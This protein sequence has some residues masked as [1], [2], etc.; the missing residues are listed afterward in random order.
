M[1]DQLKTL[2]AILVGQSIINFL[3]LE[4]IVRLETA[5]VNKEQIK[6]IRSFLSY[7][8]KVDIYVNIPD[9]MSK[10]KWLQAHEFPITNVTVSL[11]KL[12]S[13]FETKMINDI[14]LLDN[15]KVITRKIIKYLPESCYEKVTSVYFQSKQNGNIMEEMLARLHNLK[16]LNVSCPL[17]E[18]IDWIPNA[19][20]GL[21]LSSNYN[22]LIEKISIIPY[23]RRE[24]SVVEIVQYCPKLKYL[25]VTFDITEESLLA[26]STHCP[27]LNTLDIPCIPRISTEE[28]A[29]LCSSALSCI[30]SITTQFK[31]QDENIHN[32]TMALPYLTE[33]HSLHA[34]GCNDHIVLPLLSQYSLKLEVLRVR[35]LSSATAIE[36]LQLIQ[37]CSLLHTI[38]I[39]NH[40]EYTDEFVISLAQYCPKLQSLTLVSRDDITITDASILAL[41]EHCPQ[42]RE[43]ELYKCFQLTESAVVHF[44]QHCKYLH[45]L[46]L[47]D[48]GV[49][50]DTVFG[51]PVKVAVCDDIMT[52]TFDRS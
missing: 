52:Y 32:Y 16:E 27:L 30:H 15:Y 41:S 31:Q 25:S 12:N 42:L 13:T 19:I 36:L 2:S 26:L 21:Y 44:I 4:S 48:S 20:Q 33:L 40:I 6:T 43:F 18:H 7:F 24:G 14:I 39:S 49:L 22:I 28:S 5:L 29:A 38:D 17:Q 46:V 47:C 3:D 51:V 23:A 45:T 50:E 10:M 1:W 11:D 35:P 34:M 9:Q 8:S 37:Q